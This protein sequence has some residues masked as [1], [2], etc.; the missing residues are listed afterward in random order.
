MWFTSLRPKLATTF[1]T[2]HHLKSLYR[3]L[4]KHSSIYAAGQ[5]VSRVASVALIPVYT[6]VLAPEHYGIITIIEL[7]GV[8]AAGCLGLALTEAVSRF[9]FDSDDGRKQ[10]VVW[11]TGAVFVV[12][13]CVIIL[14]P[15]WIARESLATLAFGENVPRSVGGDYL[16]IALPRFGLAVL[17]T[18]LQ[19]Y[20]RVKKWSIAFVGISFLHLGLGI[21]FVLYFLLVLDLGVQGV[22]LSNLISVSVEAIILIS[23]F[24]ATRG[25]M[26]F[27]RKILASLW[28]FAYPLVFTSVLAMIMHQADVYFLRVYLDDLDQVGVYSLAYAMGQGI[29]TLCLVPFNSIWSVAIYEIAKTPEAKKVY[30]A[31]FKYFCYGLLLIMFGLSLFIRPI[32]DLIATEDYYRAADI[33]PIICLAY[34]FFSMT[35]FFNIP[36]RVHKKT[37]KMVYGALVGAIG[38]VLLN[39]YMIPRMGAPGAAWASVI[40]FGAFAAVGLFIGRRIDRIAFPIGK[41][42]AVSVTLTIAYIGHSWLE[43]RFERSLLVYALAFAMWTLAAVL[44]LGPQARQYLSRSRESRAVEKPPALTASVPER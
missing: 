24:V 11:W 14:A 40:T 39:M 32:V 19:A 2:A 7:V 43:L 38:N 26:A 22:L 41:V 10:D 29:N 27:S 42:L 16:S 44:L 18:F 12:S 13:M 37:S 4:F 1:T 21:G 23:I 34:T 15:L 35:S 25:K 31:V 30:S 33:F 28:S 5:I 20:L 36:A 17:C 9:H 3:S 6:S 8:L